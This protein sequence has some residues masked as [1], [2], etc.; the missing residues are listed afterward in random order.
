MR[1]LVENMEV[2]VW[3]LRVPG[4][5]AGK[6]DVERSNAVFY[7]DLHVLRKGAK[8]VAEMLEKHERWP[9]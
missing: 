8:P 9:P 3:D 4:G 1:L 2:K 6:V 5:R 7:M